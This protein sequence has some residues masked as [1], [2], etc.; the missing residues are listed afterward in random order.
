VER[1]SGVPGDCAGPGGEQ[2]VV[3]GVHDLLQGGER[4][5]DVGHGGAD[6][7]VG[8]VPPGAVTV[9]EAAG[10][11]VGFGGAVLIFAPWQAVSGLGSAGAIACL[12][13]AASYGISYVYMDMFLARRGISPVTLSACQLLAASGWLAI[14]LGITGVQ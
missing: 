3:A 13:A 10:L 8:A 6:E 2:G 12:A 9:R 11:L 5:E 14:A 1:L 7:H 4:G